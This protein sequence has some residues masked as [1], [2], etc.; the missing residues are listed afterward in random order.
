[1]LGHKLQA[2]AART[3]CSAVT[4]VAPFTGVSLPLDSCVGG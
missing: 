4:L 3:A 1:M 2:L